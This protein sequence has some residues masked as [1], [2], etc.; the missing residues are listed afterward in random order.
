MSEAIET[1]P[2]TG[3]DFVEHWEWAATR[4]L[5]PRDTANTYK[6]AAKNV[7]EIT[8]DQWESLDMRKLDVEDLLRRFNHLAAKKFT[9]QTS[10]TYMSRFRRAH[11]LYLSFLENPAG[12]RPPTRNFKRDRTRS[13]AGA[14]R[15]ADHATDEGVEDGGVG[16]ERLAASFVDVVKYPFPI[17]PGFI[18]QLQLPAD[19]Q[20]SEAQRLCAFLSSLAVDAPPV[21]ALPPHDDSK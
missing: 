14:G 16:E 12:Y 2:G 3:K 6:V 13:G 20:K 21:A 15:K 5:M 9:P 17:R 18:A 10:G 11:E 19:L 7:L 8:E 4:G 1:Q